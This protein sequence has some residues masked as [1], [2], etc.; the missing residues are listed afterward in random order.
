MQK[1]HFLDIK[2]LEYVYLQ[3]SG[4]SYFSALEKAMA[5]MNIKRTAIRNH[6]DKLEE[7]GLIKTVRSGVLLVNSVND[8]SAN[9]GNLIKICKCRWNE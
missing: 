2:I 3:E 4:A 7:L 6:I 8:I 9:V 5:R 1:L